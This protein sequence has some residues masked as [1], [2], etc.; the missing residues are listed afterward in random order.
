VG[1]YKTFY[2]LPAKD[3]VADGNVA[4]ELSGLP[5]QARVAAFMVQISGTATSAS[6]TAAIT[7]DMLAQLIKAVDLDSDFWYVRATGRSLHVLNRLMTGFRVAS[8]AQGVTATTG[9]VA[10]TGMLAIPASDE[11]SENPNDTAV[12]VRLLREK[13]LNFQFKTG[14]ALT[15]GTT[16]EV[17]LTN[18]KLK[19]YAIL[20]PEDGDVIPAKSRIYF[21][22]KAEASA[23]LPAG[24]YTHMCIY[25]ESTLV[26]TNAEYVKMSLAFDGAQLYD[27]VET[28]QFIAKYNQLVPRDAAQELSYQPAGS[29]EFLPLIYQPDKYK[30]TQ[31]PYADGTVRADIDDGTLTAA[32]YLYRVILPVTEA[33]TRNAAVRLGHDA[34][35]S[36]VKVKTSSKTPLQG[37]AE[38]VNRHAR[39]LPKRLES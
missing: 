16:P 28:A 8:A 11:R 18:C 31:V 32:R 27:R 14:G 19:V 9:G 36:K 4:V 26:T 7:A 23:N 17:T 1:A 39:I 21:D 29:N 34:E 20:V 33:E 15:L 37:S 24:H 25:K 6:S 12:P 13:T 35:T 38:R 2:P 30:L 10:V 5:I 22:D 3:L